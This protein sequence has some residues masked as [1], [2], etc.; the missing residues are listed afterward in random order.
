[1]NK[2][3]KII[4]SIVGITIVLLAL[5]GLTYGYYL[6]RIQGN[7]NSNSI[8]ITTADLILVYDDNNSY[9]NL[10]E[11]MPGT[12]DSKTFTVT[13]PGTQNLNEYAV[14]IDEV[15]NTLTRD[16]DLTY[17]ITCKEKGMNEDDSKYKD[18]TKTQSKTGTYP[19]V[20]SQ[21]LTNSI[22]GRSIQKYTITITYANPDEDQ[23]VDMGSIIKGRMQ[24]Y[25]TADTIELTGSVA[26]YTS[27]D[28]VQI[29]SETKTSQLL[30][31]ESTGK[32]EYKLIG[33]PI[34]EHT[35]SIRNGSTVKGSKSLSI[36]Q[37]TTA[38]YDN[39]GSL[40]ITNL[41]EKASINLGSISNNTFDLT[42]S[43]PKDKDITPPTVATELSTDTPKTYNAF[44]ITISLSDISGVDLNNSKYILNQV[45]TE[46]NGLE[47]YEWTNI[48]TNPITFSTRQIEEGTYY[49]HVVSEDLEGNTTETIN[50][51]NIA[52]SEELYFII[53]YSEGACDQYYRY[54][55]GMT[56]GEFV[57]SS[58]NNNEF[59]I[60]FG[61]EVYSYKGICNLDSANTI[62]ISGTTFVSSEPMSECNIYAN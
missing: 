37:G 43:T 3:N 45:S 39:T 31:N 52:D 2:R 18:C 59:K 5:L 54:K 17:S 10:S 53:S 8:S 58:Y 40:T 16:Y 47:G 30:Y 46:I 28:F 25:S 15:T 26:S 14:G 32:Y 11:I 7:T 12:S 42:M 55:D 1:M 23:S 33:V 29:N 27:G 48:T 13:N 4:V 60:Q 36:K 56:Y 49:L 61:N 44:D 20:N 38:G 50:E 6:T 35:I 9:I 34:G 24:I 62:I 51:I 22:N 19:K 41:S 21:I 57:N